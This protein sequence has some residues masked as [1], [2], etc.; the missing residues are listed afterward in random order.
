LWRCLSFT[1]ADSQLDTHPHC[2]QASKPFHTHA[3]T[4]IPFVWCAPGVL[5]LVL[6]F[7]W[8][9]W[10]VAD[11]V[12]VDEISAI[13]AA[14]AFFFCLLEPVSSSVSIVDSSEQDP[15][16]VDYCFSLFTLQPWVWFH[17]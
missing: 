5:F 7:F 16:P 9:C 11:A 17:Q 13:A 14:A 4:E 2:K 3:K 6:F 12:A 8:G 10:G 1:R 15:L